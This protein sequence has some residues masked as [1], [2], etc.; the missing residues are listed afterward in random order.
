MNDKLTLKTTVR[1]G[2]K[3]ITAAINYYLRHVHKKKLANPDVP[4]YFNVDTDD[5]TSS[6]I[7]YTN[8][9]VVDYNPN[10]ETR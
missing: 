10:D 3:E 6:K 9:E 1:F 2:E 4:V 7:V 8:V 5:R